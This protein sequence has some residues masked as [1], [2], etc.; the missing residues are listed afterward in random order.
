MVIRR[1][2]GV[3]GA[4]IVLVGLAEIVFPDWTRVATEYLVVPTWLRLLGVLGA[5]IGIVFVVVAVKRLVGLRLFVL[6]LG[7][8]EILGSLALF[9]APALFRDLIDA[10]Y[11]NRTPEFQLTVL[12]LSGLLR[13]GLGA[14]LLYAVAKP[15]RVE[16][17][18]G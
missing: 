7:I 15:P 4:V 14:A 16:A 5:A 2:V 11:L 3:L 12:W 18:Q 8:Y 13:I 1:I 10:L 9:A 17:N 6:I